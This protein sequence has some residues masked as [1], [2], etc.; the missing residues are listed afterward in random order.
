MLSYGYIDFLYINS[1]TYK[2]LFQRTKTV[3]N[4]ISGNHGDTIDSLIKVLKPLRGTIYDRFTRWIESK[5]FADQSRRQYAAS[6]PHI[7]LYPTYGSISPLSVKKIQLVK[8]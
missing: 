7:M 6:V 4:K 5:E 2:K 3:L 8:R 1:L